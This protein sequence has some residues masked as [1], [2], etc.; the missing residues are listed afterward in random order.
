[1][2]WEV[3]TFFSVTAGGKEKYF[4][5]TRQFTI[6]CNTEHKIWGGGT[7]R[8]IVSACIRLGMKVHFHSTG[9]QH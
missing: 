6:Y 3:R 4:N 1:M 5:K 2:S 8:A 9:F 7:A